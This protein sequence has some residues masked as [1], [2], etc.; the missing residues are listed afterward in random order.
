MGISPGFLLGD[1]A[2]HKSKIET[3]KVRKYGTPLKPQ[4]KNS[5]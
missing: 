2:F 3:M 4:S 5:S 1:R